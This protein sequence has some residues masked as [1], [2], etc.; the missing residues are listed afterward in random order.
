M[1]RD[2]P[3]TFRSFGQ[4]KYSLI[5]WG[6]ATKYFLVSSLEVRG[7][8]KSIYDVVRVEFYTFLLDWYFR[9]ELAWQQ[10]IRG[11]YRAYRKAHI[12]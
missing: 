2:F 3:R 5:N 9:Q 7:E 8:L 4:A 11:A 10:G 1:D 6:H 12:D